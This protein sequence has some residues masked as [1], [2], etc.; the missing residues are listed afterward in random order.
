MSVQSQDFVNLPLEHPRCSGYP[1]GLSLKVEAI[2]SGKIGGA[3]ARR[4]QRAHNVVDRAVDAALL[5]KPFRA[6]G[7]GDV[8]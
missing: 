4:N 1:V 2:T 3:E 8:S 7:L 6:P 5:R